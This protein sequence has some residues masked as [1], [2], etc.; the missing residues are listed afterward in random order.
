ML[1]AQIVVTTGKLGV[2]RRDRRGD[3]SSRS[4]G[5]RSGLGNDRATSHSHGR[6][7]GLGHDGASFDLVLFVLRVI[8]LLDLLI[9]SSKPA[10]LL[11]RSSTCTSVVN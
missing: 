10:N 7:S 4:H 9:S 8:A 5:S 1:P 6:R 3:R 11:G 2:V